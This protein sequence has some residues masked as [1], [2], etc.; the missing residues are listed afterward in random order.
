[1][2]DNRGKEKSISTWR[3]R[4]GK[5]ENMLEE[6]RQEGSKMEWTSR[7]SLLVT[8][9]AHLSTETLACVCD[10]VVLPA[11]LCETPCLT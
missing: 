10:T 6:M 9:E 4:R 5:K 8:S 7:K 11:R 2:S 1:M 3:Q